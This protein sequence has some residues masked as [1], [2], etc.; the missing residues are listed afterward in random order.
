MYYH[1]VF[2]YSLDE[3]F[4]YQLLIVWRAQNSLSNFKTRCNLTINLKISKPYL[5]WEEVK[6]N[7]STLDWLKEG[8]W[9][10]ESSIVLIVSNCSENSFWLHQTAYQAEIAE[11]K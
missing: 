1:L 4:M 3:L 5:Q 8:K 7:I 11:S 10:L 9:F 2:I 6:S